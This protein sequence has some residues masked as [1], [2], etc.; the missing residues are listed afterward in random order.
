MKV[1]VQKDPVSLLPLP[2]TVLHILLALADGDKHGYGIMKEVAG[3]TRG[4]VRLGPGTLYG[5]IKRLLQDGLIEKSDERPDPELDDE[6][7]VYYRL[8]GFGQ[9]VLSA[10]SRRLSQLVGMAR[11]KRVPLQ[12]AEV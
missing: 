11:A 9:R 8:T 6:R 5:G 4:A 2:L 1:T 7:R 10:E 3:R 12:F